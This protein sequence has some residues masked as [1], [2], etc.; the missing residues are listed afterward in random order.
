MGMQAGDG[1]S[2]NVDQFLRLGSAGFSAL[3]VQ[4]L[5]LCLEQELKI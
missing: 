1:V 5:K 3:K 2:E 4:F